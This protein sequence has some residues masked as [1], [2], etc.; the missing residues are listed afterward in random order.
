M[1][2]QPFEQQ[3]RQQHSHRW[4]EE[5][6]IVERRLDDVPQLIVEGKLKRMVGLTLEAI[7]CQAAIGA[8]CLVDSV[9][10]EPVEAEVVGFA[11]DRLF[12]MPTGDL[13]GVRPNARVIPTDRVYAAMVGEGLLGRVL[14][15]AG[16][17]LDSKGP[18]KVNDRV[19]LSGR[20]INPHRKKV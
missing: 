15:G 13:R 6:K 17:P 20:P 3:L 18:L 19:P 14:D 8:R 16:R 4:F 2:N 9:E 1:T 12:L 10:G 5:L 7:G 11:E